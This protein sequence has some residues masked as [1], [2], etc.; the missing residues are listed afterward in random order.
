M[1]DCASLFIAVFLLVL[2]YYS[3][4]SLIDHPLQH[5]DLAPT[6]LLPTISHPAVGHKVE[7]QREE[8]ELV[9][10]GR[11]RRH[12]DLSCAPSHCSRDT[13]TTG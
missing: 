10:A 9:P 12:W 1:F 4:P 5:S 2:I 6:L 13:R 3:P 11:V 8:E 7:Q